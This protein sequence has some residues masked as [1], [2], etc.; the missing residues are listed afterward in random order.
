[1]GG[2]GDKLSRVVILSDSNWAQALA[3]HVWSGRDGTSK[4]YL[5][6]D[7]ASGT[8]EAGALVTT[9]YNDFEHLRWLGSQQGATPIFDAAHAGQWYCVE[10]HVRLND[11]DR[12]NGIFELW[13]D[14]QLDAR[15]EGLNWVGRYSEYGLNAIFLENYWNDGAV[16]AQSRTIDNFVVSTARIGCGRR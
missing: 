14:D 11:A 4:N 16:A 12:A 10:A 13:I 9:H 5:L 1:M 2:G 6:L 8:S 7:P 3:A 15:R